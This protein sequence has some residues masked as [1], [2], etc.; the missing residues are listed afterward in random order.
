VLALSYRLRWSRWSFWTSLAI[1]LALHTL[2]I[3]VIFEKFLRNVKTVGTMVS[4]PFAMLEMF[5][6]LVI[7][8]KVDNKLTRSDSRAQQPAR[9]SC[10]SLYT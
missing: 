7:V 6:L 9:S 4:Y 5:M 1:R 3:W 8:A 2:V 10:C